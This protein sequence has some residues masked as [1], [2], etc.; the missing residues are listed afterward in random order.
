MDLETAQAGIE[1]LANNQLD[2][3]VSQLVNYPDC[4][5]LKIDF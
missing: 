4:S 5:Q 2:T 3:M 1:K